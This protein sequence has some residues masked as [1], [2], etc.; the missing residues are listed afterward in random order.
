MTSHSRNPLMNQ[1]VF[2]LYSS[3]HLW[4]ALLLNSNQ[5]I[6]VAPETTRRFFCLQPPSSLRADARSLFKHGK[7]ADETTQGKFPLFFGIDELVYVNLL[8][9]VAC[10]GS[11]IFL[12][13]SRWWFQSF[14]FSTP[15]P[16]EMIQFNEHI[17]Q[18]GGSTT[19]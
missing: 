19:N 4:V 1:S 14:L 17:F 12:I 7:P 6:F 10:C 2:F 13:F 11:N 9:V 3:C 18:M 8:L 5:V 16:G 15:N